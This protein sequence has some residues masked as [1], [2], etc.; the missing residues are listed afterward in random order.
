[1]PGNNL[2]PLCQQA[3]I[4]EAATNSPFAGQAAFSPAR[5]SGEALGDA[6]LAAGNGAYEMQ[7]VRGR[8]RLLLPDMNGVGTYMMMDR[9]PSL[10]SL[11]MPRLQRHLDLWP[12]AQSSVCCRPLCSRESCRLPKPG[13]PATGL[14]SLQA[15][16]SVCNA[17]C[18]TGFCLQ[19]PLYESTGVGITSAHRRLTQR[20]SGLSFFVL[21]PSNL[22]H[23]R[24]RRSS[25][26]EAGRPAAVARV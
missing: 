22:L 19:Y 5:R 4:S 3:A 11:Q 2:L 26:Q 9:G 16:T 8:C 25:T 17:S 15:R 7:Q 21:L 24:L 14:Q 10:N 18:C 23:N 13:A 6:L 1:M 20:L 12:A